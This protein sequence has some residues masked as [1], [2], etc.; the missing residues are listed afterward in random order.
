MLATLAKPGEQEVLWR[1]AVE[2]RRD[3]AG[4]SSGLE[5]YPIGATMIRR[6][7]GP[8]GRPTAR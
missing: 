8:I 1:G 3:L 4:S 7:H 5:L 2:E 6:P